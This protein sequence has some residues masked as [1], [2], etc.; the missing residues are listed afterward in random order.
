MISLKGW[1]KDKGRLQEEADFETGT[2]RAEFIKA[3]EEES[4][5]KECCINQKK[6]GGSLIDTAFQVQL[7]IATH[8][9]RWEIELEINLKMIIGAKGMALSYVMI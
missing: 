6:T 7:E 8:W 1:V 3:I 5:R 2:T 4:E 9:Y